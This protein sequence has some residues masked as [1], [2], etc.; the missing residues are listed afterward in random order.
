VG[1][2]VDVFELATVEGREELFA[3]TSKAVRAIRSK[4]AA[5]SSGVS[6]VTPTDALLS[7]ID[8][9]TPPSSTRPST[10]TCLQGATDESLAA[11]RGACAVTRSGRVN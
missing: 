10:T 6:S 5:A 2:W 4:A 3:L 7:A 1:I 9:L 11:S 8:M